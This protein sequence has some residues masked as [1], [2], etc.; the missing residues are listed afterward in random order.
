MLQLRF[1]SNPCTL[2]LVILQTC[3]TLPKLLCNF[4][5]EDVSTWNAP[6][7][8]L[9]RIWVSKSILMTSPCLAHSYLLPSLQSPFPGPPVHLPR[10]LL[11]RGELKYPLLEPDLGDALTLRD[12]LKDP[13][14]DSASKPQ[15]SEPARQCSASPL[16]P[17][18]LSCPMSSR[19]ST[20]PKDSLAH[21]YG[22]R[23]TFTD[24][25]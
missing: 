7:Y 4:A 5:P 11:A 18:D 9:L 19:H 1:N 3:L 10:L 22:K 24:T 12:I 13:Q 23:C 17:L 21:C 20:L 8:P 2:P 16:P 25:A 14:L 15:L 6:P